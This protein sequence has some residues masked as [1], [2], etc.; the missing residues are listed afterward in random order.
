MTDIAKRP[1]LISELQD[2]LNLAKSVFRSDASILNEL[3]TKINRG[4]FF[5][6]KA[7]IFISQREFTKEDIL[8][9]SHAIL[10]ELKGAKI[11]IP[12]KESLL[13]LEPSYRWLEKL[14]YFWFKKQ[15]ASPFDTMSAE[16][17]GSK[18][19]VLFNLETSWRVCL[20][21]TLFEREYS[22]HSQE[23][24]QIVKYGQA[25]E[26]RD[27]RIRE[28][29]E[30]YAHLVWTR[31]TNNL[32][33][34]PALTPKELQV[35]VDR[36]RLYNINTWDPVY[37]QLKE[38]E[39]RYLRVMESFQRFKNTE[40][41]IN[42]VDHRNIEERASKVLELRNHLQ[43][44]KVR[45]EEAIQAVN[46]ALKVLEWM[47]KARNIY[48]LW[49]EGK[50]FNYQTLNE[51]ASAGA[52]MNISPE[53]P[54]LQFIRERL[55][56]LTAVMEHHSRF[57][58]TQ[59]DFAEAVRSISQNPDENARRRLIYE[60]C[61]KKPTLVDC[62]NL[63]ELIKS[64]GLEIEANELEKLEVNV[65]KTEEWCRQLDLFI[66]NNKLENEKYNLPADRATKINAELIKFRNQVFN[67]PFQVESAEDKIN[68]YD[69]SFTALARLSNL[70]KNRNTLAD[71]IALLKRADEL[72]PTLG[73]QESTFYRVLN[74][75]IQLST[76][77]TAQINEYR[78][79][80]EKLN[81]VINAAKENPNAKSDSVA[82]IRKDVK[83]AMELKRLEED[84]NKCKIDM[85]E[86]RKYLLE[87]Y[88][89]VKKML[90]TYNQ[91]CVESLAKGTKEP[92]SNFLALQE[93]FRRLPV[94]LINE[95]RNLEQLIQKARFFQKSLEDSKRQYRDSKSETKFKESAME[96]YKQIPI[97]VKE[98]ED[99]LKDRNAVRE[100]MVSFSKR[101]EELR[102][103][104][105]LDF[106]EI[107]QLAGQIDE[108]NMALGQELEDLKCDVWNLQVESIR[109]C[110]E[111][112]QKG[113]NEEFRIRFSLLKALLADGYALLTTKT[114]IA[115]LRDNVM[116]IEQ[117]LSSAEA[118]LN[119]V[120][121]IKFVE[122]LESFHSSHQ[123]FVDIK[124]EII[125][126]K[127]KLGLD[128]NF[129]P[130]L[131]SHVKNIFQYPDEQ[132]ISIIQQEKAA[133]APQRTSPKMR[134]LGFNLQKSKSDKKSLERT[135]NEKK[136]PSRLAKLL[137]KDKQRTPTT[138]L[139]Q[140][141]KTQ[142]ANKDNRMS[143]ETS[144]NRD[145]GDWELKKKVKLTST[146]ESAN[147]VIDKDK[148]HLKPP[149]EKKVKKVDETAR[150]ENRRKLG[151]AL[152]QNP[153][154][155]E[156]Q[157][158]QIKKYSK[159]IEV[160]LFSEYHE[161]YAKYTG[162]SEAIRAFL[163]KLKKYKFLSKMVLNKHFALDTLKSLTKV[164]DSELP[165]YEQRSETRLSKEKK[166]PSKKPKATATSKSSNASSSQVDD[167]RLLLGGPTQVQA[168][169]RF[170]A[171]V[172]SQKKEPVKKEPSTLANSKFEPL[173]PEEEEQVPHSRKKHKLADEPS[174]FSDEEYSSN[175]MISKSEISGGNQQLMD[176]IKPEES[177]NSFEASNSRKE[178]ILFDPDNDEAE[179][180]KSITTMQ[181]SSYDPFNVEVEMPAEEGPS[182]M[183][184]IEDTD[185]PKGSVLK[186]NYLAAL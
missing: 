186:V 113:F 85:S 49:Q 25:I 22:R 7:E 109:K 38:I 60:V 146:G 10:N 151:M 142:S 135:A 71:W 184:E 171:L 40:G 116:Y 73:I 119:E 76:K 120:Y 82:Q 62:K 124:E 13:A 131:E 36:A 153:H 181:K 30:K 94:S 75:Q 164:K 63:I 1:A 147:K 129:Q 150:Q 174:Y 107:R 170:Q 27:V 12:I 61:K 55:D 89:K 28:V 14:Y 132:I 3:E 5:Q 102:R 34:R 53:N 158:E 112:V 148:V 166:N 31:E 47:A 64:S 67:L 157:E 58:K 149:P 52:L 168:P 152:R 35:V 41:V 11:E 51:I 37:I 128:P 140:G 101:V 17:S 50:R 100:R 87:L 127:V 99:I 177:A 79:L 6:E 176:E 57:K 72:K 44:L 103:G 173:S 183:P 169:S 172:T 162:K 29:F 42:L 167:L 115:K 32:L 54:L 118:E 160:N 175:K 46:E 182:S 96:Q 86:E 141:D 66:A 84:L 144:V 83:N 125:E 20:D 91:Y 159:D 133:A 45:N 98:A 179:F 185:F 39:T 18:G 104:P 121:N 59:S 105:K 136:T 134:G 165:V 88:G 97:V 163:E 139:V 70:Y 161:D 33:S 69:W 43:N 180:S 74:E 8:E 92:L 68:V 110:Q 19:K 48:K 80:E 21:T 56:A 122:L 111:N 155:G 126:Y 156:L 90:D 65:A 95:E 81:S 154:F 137:E 138:K 15:A 117:L 77:I 178:A 4:K 114:A 78:A 143:P 93:N 23:L 24:S 108:I 145:N 9:K 106:S 16:S 2:K 130:I 123:S 26:H